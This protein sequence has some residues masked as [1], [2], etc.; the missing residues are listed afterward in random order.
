[1][2]AISKRDDYLGQRRKNNQGY[3]MEIIK[4]NT[5]DD[6]VVEFFE[7]YPWITH[8]KI[9]CFKKGEITNRYAPAVAGVGITGTK[10]PTCDAEG[11]HT[12]DYQVWSNMI[13]RCYDPISQER[14]PSYKDVTCDDRWKYFE[15]FYEWIHSQDNYNV[16]SQLKDYGVDKDILFKG[17]REYS[18]DKC[19]LVPTRVNNLLLK[20][21][22]IRGDY[23]IGVTY[24]PRNKKYV[25]SCGGHQNHVY[26]GIYKTP[27]EAFMA[28]KKYKEKY[29][30][31]VA[32][33]EFN[34]GTIT[35][36]C[37]DALMNYEINITD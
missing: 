17:N 37:Y 16:V 20:S 23:P 21:D 6:I 27:E 25:A 34:K 30:K 31:E 29:I 4:Y 3:D 32:T 13:K 1:M 22:K 15:T 35:K 2:A 9:C 5:Y 10:Y 33:E 14:N 26:L 28:Y 19:M 7:P 24:Y 11:K 12:R 36:Q 8:S 18:P